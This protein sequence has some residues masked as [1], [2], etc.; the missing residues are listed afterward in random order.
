[1]LIILETEIFG[2]IPSFEEQYGLKQIGYGASTPEPRTNTVEVPGRN[3]L[4]DLTGAMGP[5]TYNNREVWGC[6]REYGDTSAHMI[7]Y[8]NI[9]NKYHGQRVKVVL[10]AEPDYY[11]DGRCTVSTD[12][13]NKKA[14][15]INLSVDADPFKYPV[16]A[17][18][19]DWLWDPF[20]FETGVIRNYS[21]IVISGTRSVGIIGYE[22]PESPKFYVTL[23]SGQSSMRM[24][25]DGNTYYLHNGMNSFPQIVISS[26]DV[27]TD[28]NQFTFTGYGKVS[29]DMRGGIL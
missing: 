28:I 17:S 8:S 16:Y 27:H 12:Y 11:Y 24:V 2:D 14:R 3:G 22:Q 5:V 7:K 13:T 23:N 9:L 1:M 25:F 18:D 20:N 19:E 29:V 10:D 26:Q 4:L 15:L 6:F 21:N